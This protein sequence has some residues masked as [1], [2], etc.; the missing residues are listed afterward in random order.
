M[1]AFLFSVA[2]FF[3]GIVLGWSIGFLWNPPSYEDVIPLILVGAVAGPVA[4][5]LLARRK[6]VRDV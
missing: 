1:R 5:A 3:A 6:P 4:G 2:G